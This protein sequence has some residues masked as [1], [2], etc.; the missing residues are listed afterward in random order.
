MKLRPFCFSLGIAVVLSL[1]GC[2]SLRDA[3]PVDRLSLEKPG[4]T[5]ANARSGRFVIRAL[6]GQGMEGD[7]RGAQGRF[8]WLEFQPT[9]HRSSGFDPPGRQVL[10]WL[11]ALGQS[12]GSLEKIYG[13]Q[14]P[15]RVYDDQGHPLSQR[16]QIRLLA[17]LFGNANAEKISDDDIAQLLNNLMAIFQQ[18]IEL[19]G[20]VQRSRFR[21]GD[22]EVSLIVAPDPA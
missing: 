7:E 20:G 16:S 8:E 22:L 17:S 6:A 18:A 5:V 14:N 1:G 2:V 12:T 21:F 19:S 9:P 15:V 13:A 4:E 3:S 10:I 11:G